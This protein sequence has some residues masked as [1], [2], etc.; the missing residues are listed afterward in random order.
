[1]Q[2]KS[3]HQQ[4]ELEDLNPSKKL[5]TRVEVI[6]QSG[7]LPLF[8]RSLTF[9][10]SFFILNPWNK[11]KPSLQKHSQ[12]TARVLKIPLQECS[13]VV[14]RLYHLHCI[15][16]VKE[17]FYLN[18]MKKSVFPF[19]NWIANQNTRT[20]ITPDTISRTSTATSDA[21]AVMRGSF[22]LL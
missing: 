8:K 17:F 9:G 11:A 10:Y 16:F 7:F 4:A 18:A 20:I 3:N 19:T 13:C 2:N 14:Y 1:M 15:C 21:A 12:K 5:S 22:T 6:Y